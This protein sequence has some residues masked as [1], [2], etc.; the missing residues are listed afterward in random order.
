V[1]ARRAGGLNTWHAGSLP[2]TSSLLVR[3]HDGLHWAVLFNSRET[4]SGTWPSH[5]I[6]P[7]L[8]Q[9]ASAV[10]EWP[11]TDLFEHFAPDGPAAA[12]EPTAAAKP[13]AAAY[14]PTAAAYEPTVTR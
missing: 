14:E 7:L 2:G 10:P 13:T 12:A 11:E 3:R 6:D 8:H 4:P 9:A 5:L 1:R